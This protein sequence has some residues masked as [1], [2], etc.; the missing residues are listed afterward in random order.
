M[1]G[2]DLPLTAQ[3]LTG[4][5]LVLAGIVSAALA[6]RLRVP[7]LLLFLGVGM[8]V[9][10]D[11]LALVRFSDERLVQAVAIVA[12]V[13]ILLD[14]GL[15][16]DV[17]RLRDVVV[18]AGLLA[19]AGVAI[20]AGVVAVTAWL[21]LDVDVTTALLLGAVVASTDAAAVFVVLRGMRL[22][23]R[24]RL[25]LE[26]E[27]GGNDPAAVLLTVA[28]LEYWRSGPAAGELVTFALRQLTGGLVVGAAIGWS[29]AWLLNVWKLL[30]AAVL[31]A[32]VLAVGGLAYGTAT[33]VGASGFLAVYLAGLVLGARL[34]RDRH[35]VLVFHQGLAVT[36]QVGLFLLLSILVFP[37]QLPGAAVSALGISA[38]LV[39]VAR[40]LAVLALLPWFGWRPGELT[41][42][43]WAGLRGA[44]PIVLATFP[45]TA[46]YP[47]GN[48]IF[49]VVFFVVVVSVALQGLT[50]PLLA[51]A[52]RLDRP[53][54]SERAARQ[55]QASGADRT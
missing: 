7:A 38:A 49:N 35:P 43:S 41:L 44:V 2:L 9:A 54:Q 11:G 15:T 45:L 40:P 27:S 12:L 13:V 26:V 17:G 20:T 37:S 21:L 52:L 50:V 34:R 24:V 53:D 47:D 51:R 31:P 55:P 16:T 36:A 29:A 32:T 30:P 42:V 46:G 18:P 25:L 3:I 8:L 19:T 4:S 6:E 23:R 39:F 33:D 48:L 1:V 22:P 28:V 14:G 5:L 10:D